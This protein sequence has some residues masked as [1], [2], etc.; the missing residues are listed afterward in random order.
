MPTT[1]ICSVHDLTG[2]H[3]REAAA[4]SAELR[5]LGVDAV[6]GGPRLYFY[7]DGLKLHGGEKG[8]KELLHVDFASDSFLYRLRHGGGRKQPL[9]RAIGLRPG[10]N[11]TVFDATAGLGRDGFLLAALGCQ[12]MLCERSAIIHALLDDGL[13][14][15]GKNPR[16]INTAQRITLLR[17][18]S[19]EVLASL[20]AAQRP[21]VIYLDPMFPHRGKSALVKKEMRL[22]RAVVGDDY[23]TEG[24]LRLCL[25]Q[26]IKRVVCKRPRAASPLS[27]PP[28]S[29]SISTPKHRFDVYLCSAA[30]NG[31]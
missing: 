25:G 5:A 12:V 7:A 16:L 3:A 4:L 15:A 21:E 22:V 24:L 29:F 19:L 8:G 28:A 10:Y 27:G 6:D 23:D 1:C 14:R 9:G 17:A 2:H 31:G 13:R 26:A 18:D 30:T 20:K 11:P